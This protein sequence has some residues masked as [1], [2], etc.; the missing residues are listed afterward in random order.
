MPLLAPFA[1]AR[2]KT[3]TRHIIL[4]RVEDS[5]GVEGW[6]ECVA[7]EL[8]DYTEEWTESAWV[9]LDRLLA[10]ALVAGRDVSVRGNRMARAALEAASFDLEAR[11]R[12]MPLWQLLG[13]THREIP[14][15]VTIGLDDSVSA[16]LEKIESE[17][18][19]GY[20]R[21][22]IKIKPGQDVDLIG[23]IRQRFP[24]IEL[25]ADANG[26]Y[27]LVDADDLAALDDFD[28]MMIEQ[29]LAWDDVV[30]HA[31]LQRKIRTPICL[32][33]SLRSAADTRHAIRLGSCRIVNLKM[34]R[35]GGYRESLAIEAFCR[36][37]QVPLWCGGMLESGIGRAHNIAL[38]TLPGFTLPGDTSASSRYWAEDIIESPVTVTPRG[39]VVPPTTP[40]LGFEVRRDLVNKLTIR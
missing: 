27:T 9:T 29:P 36:E 3:T 15:G 10:P 1:T 18:R 21:V 17:L 38:S 19:A 5:D 39:T 8:P 2:G 23:A 14:C 24:N 4:V 37:A 16:L 34:G 28:L 12:G 33:E 25:M 40:G 22:K 13:G 31:F 11:R 26:A 20:Q 7:T 35:V 6:G 32:D 30:E